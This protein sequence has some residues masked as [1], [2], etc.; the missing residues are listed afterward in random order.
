MAILAFRIKTYWNDGVACRL[1]WYFGGKCPHALF[2]E[3][4]SHLTI[5]PLLQV[6]SS[7]HAAPRPFTSSL[8]LAL[9]VRSLCWLKSWLLKLGYKLGEDAFGKDLIGLAQTGS[10]KTGAFA[11]PILQSLLESPQ[12]FFACVLS[13]TR[14]D[15]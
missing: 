5:P 12:A 2:L 13:P 10:G 3:V 1:R 4:I 14:F 9:S 6:Y 11:L 7:F 15:I 8:S